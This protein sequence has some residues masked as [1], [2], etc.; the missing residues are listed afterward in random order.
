[1]LIRLKAFGLNR[2][3]MFTRQGHSTTVNF[4][5]I[6]GIEAADVIEEAPEKE[7]KFREGDVVAAAMGGIG[8]DS[9]GRYAEYNVV[10]AWQVQVIRSADKS[11]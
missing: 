2:F 1:M 6:L 4:L 9:V 10:P 11:S 8:R 3:E 7:D 5:R